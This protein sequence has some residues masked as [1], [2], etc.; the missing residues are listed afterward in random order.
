MLRRLIQRHRIVVALVLLN[1]LFCYGSYAEN[2]MQ[3]KKTA[4]NSITIEI[5]N[6]DA[7]AG[8]QFSVQAR[9]GI[10]W[11][12][13]E[14]SERT[15]AAGMVIY[16]FLANDSTL[17]VVILAPYQS[18]LP[19]GHGIIGGIDFTLPFS[20]SQDTFSVN[21]S[22]LVICDELAHSLE[23]SIEKL[24][25]NRESGPGVVSFTLDQNHP[26]PFNPSTTISYKIER[27]SNVHLAVYDIVGRL[28]NTLVSEFQNAGQYTVRWNA[29]D[30][31]SS[32]LASGVYFARLQVDGKVATK[33]MILTK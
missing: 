14:G 18:S 17:N 19:S 11:K 9:G 31:R 5:T 24:V 12:S 30:N 32:K 2:R 29:D 27:A 1:C 22:G 8:L 13:Y 15:G 25:W 26:N 28:T 21:L 20:A 10:V 6:A 16:Q 4:G 7:I 3:L 23:V 33:K